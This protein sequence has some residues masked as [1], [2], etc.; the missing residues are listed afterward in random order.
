M[1]CAIKR[2]SMMS[3]IYRAAI[4]CRLS[5]DD[6]Q[7]GDSVSIETQKLMLTKFCNDQG[8]EI[9]DIY[10]DDGYSGLNF[11]RPSFKRLIE[12][13]E[14]EKFNIVITKDLSR[15]GR[16][17]IQ[18]GYYIDVYFTSKKVRYIAVN[19]SIDTKHEN[20]D[21]APF[22]NILNDMYA[23]DLS[24]KVK[25]AKQQ[26]AQNG[27][28]ISAQ[29]PFGYKVN[30]V[31]K[32]QLIIDQEVAEIVKFIFE[33][34][35]EGNSL[36]EIAR[37]LEEKKYIAPSVYKVING[38]T[39]FLR[40]A[41][42]KSQM[43]QWNYQT[44]KSIVSNPVYAGDMVNHKVETVNYKTKK[45]VR[46]PKEE[47]IIVSN[48]HEAIV[49]RELFNKANKTVLGRRKPN[50]KFD[51]IFKG[52]I[53]CSECGGEMQLIAKRLKNTSKPMFRCLQHVIDKSQCTHN[54]YIYYE[55]LIFEI[56]KQI[57][58]LIERYIESSCYTKLCET[59]TELICAQVEEN[60]E[61]IWQNRLSETS[62]QIKE[63]YKKL[64][65]DNNDQFQKIEIS[66]LLE[67]QKSAIR[68]ITSGEGKNT[69][70]IDRA[71]IIDIVSKEIKEYIRKLAQNQNI[72]KK[73]INRIEIGHLNR[74]N[75][76]VYQELKLYYKVT[77][78]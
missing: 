54:H 68:K 56:Q 74:K 39:R 59:I 58:S 78:Q 16:D 45:R 64:L 47:Y 15:L 8:F 13:L 32:N 11:N 67:K 75:T 14:D 23:K 65:K 30:P 35:S 52:M 1:R 66:D 48:T 72:I 3:E 9:F 34:A 36:S 42:T 69:Y 12:D 2:K 53:F 63:Y 40:Y 37:K 29:P 25:S 17:Y 61:A 55:D 76:G 38:D 22:K 49:D 19:D 62:K 46:V 18:T 6:E 28:Y 50:H 41:R 27:L 7:S 21:I 77:L 44:V 73:L 26:R 57:E 5:K 20:N 10:V 70:L 43:Y 60:R 51:N 24:R 4:Y 31:N 71:S 33:L